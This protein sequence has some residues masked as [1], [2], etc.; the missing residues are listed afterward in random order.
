M[1]LATTHGSSSDV[2]CRSD[3]GYGSSDRSGSEW[4]VVSAVCARIQ[5][6]QRLRT[7]LITRWIASVTS[8][9]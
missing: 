4:P 3:H 9:G 5:A 1:S 8:L 6:P 7:F 2:A